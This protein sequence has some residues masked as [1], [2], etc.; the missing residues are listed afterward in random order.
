VTHAQGLPVSSLDGHRILALTN[1]IGAPARV[2]ESRSAQLWCA[3]SDGLLEQ[4]GTGWN[5]HPI[6]EIAAEFRA[7][8]IRAV[9]SI[10]LLPLDR[11]RILVLLPDQLLEYDAGEHRSTVFPSTG[12]SQ[13]QRF[14][15]L[16]PSLD[17][18]VWI[19]GSRGLLRIRGPLRQIRPGSPIEEHP[20][21]TEF[22]P[23]EPQRPHEASNGSVVLSADHPITRDRWVLRFAEGR[24]QRWNIPGY[25]VR[26]AWSGPDGDLWAH[27]SSALLRLDPE[28]QLVRPRVILQAGR[29]ADLAV[30]PHGAAWL[31]TSDGVY[32]V[33]PLPWRPAPGFDA[34]HGAALVVT[35]DRRG[36]IVVAAERG[37]HWQDG[38]G[39][40]FAEIL[41]PS[42]DEPAGS[43]RIAVPLDDGGLLI[44]RTNGLVALDAEGRPRSL[45]PELAR[46]QP[47]G[48]LPDGR[49]ILRSASGADD[50]LLLFDGASAR[51]F[52][53]LPAHAALGE[54]TLAL[55]S[56]SGEFWLGFESGLAVRRG[57]RWTEA[58]PDLPSRA[59]RAEMNTNEGVFAALELPDGRLLFGGDD[60]VREFDGQRWTVLRRGLD[61]VH[62]L[63]TARDG[64][65][66][67]AS[68]NGLHRYKEKSWLTLSEEEG[69]PSAAVFSVFQDGSGVLWAGTAR[70]LF[71]FDPRADTDPPESFIATADLPE[72]AGDLRALFV[73]GGDD[74]WRFSTSGRL[75][76]SS[77]LD[78]EPWSAWRTA[79]S[80]QYT[81][82]AAGAHRFEVRAMDPC[83]NIQP[84]PATLEFSVAL[85]W[86]RDPRLVATSAALAVLAV[87][88][89]V[90]AFLSYIRLKRSYAEVERQVAERSA[91]LE[92][93]N[94]ELLH[95]QKMRALGTL[96]AGVAHDFNNLLSIIRGSAQLAE[97]QLDDRDKARQRLQRIKTAVDQGAGL[98]KAMLGY[99]RGTASPR[100][101]SD[102]HEIVTRAVRLFE[103]GNPGRTELSP[104]R[105]PGLRIVTSPEMLQQII[106]NLLQNA[107]E[108]SPADQPVRVEITQTPRLP[109]DCLLKP[110]PADGY[111]E[112]SVKDR[113]LG[114][115]PEN[116]IRIF[117]PFF[118]TKAF[119]SRRGTG[120]GLSMAYEFAKELGAGIAVDSVVG[121]GST[122][123]IFLP[124][125][126]LPPPG[127]A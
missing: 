95:S 51:P 123:R 60:T 43:A 6:P 81:N 7:S 87:M 86:F 45:P 97:G 27:S 37:L 94:A 114:I 64:A 31:A 122:F 68:G 62:A 69:L 101:D 47:L 56:K 32:R 8:P 36:R 2:H 121:K 19:S 115:P 124:R 85:P 35:T 17:D 11:N 50:R 1:A 53:D 23:L 116:L 39:W 28:G 79:S 9:R 15:D 34:T 77:H 67:V 125:A 90:Q 22:G 16:A 98:V 118:T 117:E 111:L 44:R 14:S 24:W 73:F 72:R 75:M 88:L 33:A 71:T 127:S 105:E 99:S 4:T 102:P 20:F 66:W 40:R 109:A 89:G 30:E 26:Q 74:R 58:D 57:D 48:T 42:P 18:G 65:I 70:G 110:S 38:T 120:L 63:Q 59:E 41:E 96:A 108:A 93:A 107:T 13:P 55:Q 119:S 25:N 12:I 78:N 54:P 61:R 103:E 46:A 83:G 82:V 80:V 91:A 113:G 104:T 100:K 5:R 92:K 84:Q 126:P 49:I 3:T 106:L 29:I 52:A 21:P 10:P 76:F 112:I